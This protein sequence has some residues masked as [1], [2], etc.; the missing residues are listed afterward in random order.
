LEKDPQK[1]IPTALVL[2]N[3]LR[4]MEHALSL[5][6]RVMQPD[7]LGRDDE[8]RLV[9]EDNPS[10]QTQPVGLTVSRPSGKE[11]KPLSTSEKE[12]DYRLSGVEPTIVTGLGGSAPPRP[13]A[14]TP[15]AG[16]ARGGS[17][18]SAHTVAEAGADAIGL[19]L[20]PAQRRAQFTHVSEAELRGRAEDSDEVS[21]RIWLTAGLLLVTAAAI[22]GGVI[23]FASRPPSADQLYSRVKGAMDDGGV[24]ELVS[25]ETDLD[26]FIETYAADPR[27]AELRGFQDELELYRLQ[28][29]FEARAKR[30]AG[31]AELSPVERA[32]LEAVRLAASDP[33]LA[34][35]RFQA[36]IDVYGGTEEPGLTP[37]QRK[38]RGQCLELAAKQIERLKETVTTLNAQQRTAVRR[39]LDR[40]GKLAEKD[41]A[42]AAKIWRGIVTLYADKPWAKDLVEQAEAKL[43]DKQ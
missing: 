32:Y 12:H 30:P 3:R 20:E 25:V 5:D 24:E 13:G 4:A 14:G 11:T 40:A 38:T 34:L 42:A 18:H 28:R 26:K 1:R 29:R 39:Q 21:T 9:P 7:D 15:A 31:V 10:H 43:A 16:A 17:I 41:K 19:V 6:T 35:A 36:L 23:Y 22:I 33:E 2:M 8:L 27:A 37:V